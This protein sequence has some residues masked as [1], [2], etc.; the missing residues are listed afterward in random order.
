M[1]LKRWAALC[2]VVNTLMPPYLRA[3]LQALNLNSKV[4]LN[5]SAFSILAV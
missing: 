3:L 2:S 1:L 4:S 5:V